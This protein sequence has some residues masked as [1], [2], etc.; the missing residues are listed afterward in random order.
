MLVS[1]L[2]LLTVGRVGVDLYA[3]QLGVPLAEVRTFRKSLGGTATNVAVACARL[4]QLPTLPFA[5]GRRLR[6]RTL[7]KCRN[8]LV[9]PTFFAG[10]H[11]ARVHRELDLARGFGERLR[12]RVL[13]R[14]PTL[15]A[16]AVLG[17][18]VAYRFRG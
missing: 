14:L 15:H 11:F 16:L 5:W 18:D 7:L 3:E 17:A 4:G 1:D 6:P 13:V 2:E 12:R 8:F 9:F 10:V